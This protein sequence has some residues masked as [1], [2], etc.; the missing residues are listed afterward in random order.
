VRNVLIEDGIERDSRHEVGY[1]AIRKTKPVLDSA[2][3]SE[4]SISAAPPEEQIA[5]SSAEYFESFKLENADMTTSQYYS[6]SGLLVDSVS[7]KSD[8]PTDAP[9]F[10]PAPKQT[11]QA[12]DVD[13][14]DAVAGPL[15]EMLSTS[16][17]DLPVDSKPHKF[18][19]YASGSDANFS[20][21]DTILMQMV[22]KT[23]G[24]VS[25]EDGGQLSEPPTVPPPPVPAI[26]RR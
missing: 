23:T 20:A 1:G 12:F 10:P 19:S 9:P 17:N 18:S 8:A 2:F 15:R 25:H 11:M 13:S 26:I 5:E 6:N 16:L 22:E 21:K 4:V 3:Q 7:E 14:L 24:S